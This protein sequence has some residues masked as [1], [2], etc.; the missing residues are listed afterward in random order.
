MTPKLSS[1]TIFFPFYNDAGTV[2]QLICD[3]YAYGRQLTDDLEVMALAGGTS[4][5]DTWEKILEVQK[6]YPDLK[7]M[8]KRDN[9]E[10][11]AVIKYGFAAATR[12]WIFYT[13][14]D[15]QY[16]LDD[17]PRLAEAQMRTGA[18]VV[19]GYKT[20]RGDHIVRRVLG[21][22]YRKL[23]R[24]IFHLPIH[25]LDCDFRLIRRSSLDKCVF[26]SHDSSILLELVKELQ[27]TGAVFTEI[28]VSHY[29]RTY[30]RSNYRAFDLVREKLI[31]DAKVYWTYMK[32]RGAHKETKQ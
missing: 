11:Y 7:I 6:E 31:G 4:R 32:N 22:G 2:A 9:W 3:A 30:G 14:G 15:A 23:T 28:P 5:D 18:D 10:G 27:H 24:L 13:D 19:N 16:H 1:L 12:D 26:H 25:D 21:D 29:R 20:R 17:L 8:D